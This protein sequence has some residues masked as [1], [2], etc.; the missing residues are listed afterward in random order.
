MTVPRK[1]TS[2]QHVLIHQHR[3][4]PYL[5]DALSSSLPAQS[6]LF[7]EDLYPDTVGPEP[8]AEAD[9]WFEG[10]DAPPV[11]ISLKDGFVA[12]TKTKEFKVHKSLL[13]TTTACAGS[14]QDSSGVR[15]LDPKTFN[16]YYIIG[17][18]TTSTIFISSGFTQS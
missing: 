18:F 5:L 3:F 12:T 14:Q 17:L 2:Q 11:L 9:E 4:L 15:L 7:Q 6:D 10:K 1:V 16:N 8:S 13:K